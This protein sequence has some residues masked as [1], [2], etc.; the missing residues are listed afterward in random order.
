M[1]GLSR[2]RLYEFIKTGDIEVIK[3]GRSTA[4]CRCL[5]LAIITVGKATL[6]LIAARPLT[7]R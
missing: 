4:V 1:I 5:T 7:S 6:G 2:S 3:V